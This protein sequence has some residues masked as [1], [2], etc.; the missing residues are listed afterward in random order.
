MTIRGGGRVVKQE[1]LGPLTCGTVALM[2]STEHGVFNDEGCIERDFW[3]SDAA[4][5]AVAVLRA[6]GDEHAYSAAMCTE[7]EEQPAGHCEEC[8]AEDDEDSEDDEL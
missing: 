1:L 7:H 3:T 4:E 6:E 8:D 2:T 5:R